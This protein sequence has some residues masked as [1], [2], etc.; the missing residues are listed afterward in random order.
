MIPA[1]ALLSG[2]HI[3]AEFQCHAACHGTV[4]LRFMA[5]GTSTA[6]GAPLAKLSFS[7]H[8][9]S[10]ST[11]VINPTAGALAK[12]AHS[13]ALAVQL[14]VSVAAGHAKAT[15]IVSSLEL[16]RKLPATSNKV[17]SARASAL[18]RA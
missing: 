12:L 8:N 18:H 15:T 9:K 1:V 16:T 6:T 11:L 17:K 2:H 4:S 7:L 14:T 5:T 3:N 13:Q 10:V